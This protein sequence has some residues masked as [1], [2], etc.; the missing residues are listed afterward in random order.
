MEVSLTESDSKYQLA[1]VE[2]K[3]V[4][5]LE[6]KLWQVQSTED[7][8]QGDDQPILGQLKMVV[9]PLVHN[10]DNISMEMLAAELVSKPE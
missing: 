3:K 1:K 4:F 8:G 2:K 5:L 6:N 9:R 7:G 10:L